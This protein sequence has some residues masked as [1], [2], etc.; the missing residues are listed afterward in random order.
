MAIII[1]EEKRKINWFAAFVIILVL[2]ILFVSVYY[3]FFSGEPLIEKV[4]PLQ[5]E[6]QSLNQLSSVKF[7]PALIADNNLFQLLRKYVNPIE[8]GPTGKDNPFLR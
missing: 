8:I 6:L 5:P 7:D 2:A 1:E 3:L 4:I